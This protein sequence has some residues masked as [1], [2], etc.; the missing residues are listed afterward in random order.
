MLI[1]LSNLSIYSKMVNFLFSA[2]FGSHFCYHTN[3]K[4]QSN[5][6]LLHFVYCSSKLVR[7]RWRKTNLRAPP[8]S[9]WSSI[10]FGLSLC[11]SVCLS[12]CYCGHSNLVILNRISSSS[13]MYFFRRLIIK[14]ADNMATPYQFTFSH[15]CGHSNLVI[16]SKFHI[17]IA[18]IK[19]W[20]K[21]EYKFCLTNDN[22]D[23]RQNGRQNGRRQS[24]CIFLLLWSLQL[25]HF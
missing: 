14:M 19:P 25:S 16:S 1:S 17:W 4:S 6:R 20:F 23:G 8:T 11:P 5:L 12:V 21:F 10:V 18:S 22:Q 2:Y 24:V 9:W 3:D 13:D 15:C 7:R